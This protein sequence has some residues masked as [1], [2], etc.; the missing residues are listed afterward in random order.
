MKLALSSPCCNNCAIHSASLTSVLRPGTALMCCALTTSSSICPSRMLYTGFQSTALASLASKHLRSPLADR[1]PP[2]P[3]PPR[4][5]APPQAGH[6]HLLVHVQPTA[7]LV[8]NLHDRLLSRFHPAASGG[9][10]ESKSLLCA[11]LPAE[12][13]KTWCLRTPRS[14]SF[15]G[16]QHQA[17]IDLCSL[18]RVE[19]RLTFSSN[20][21]PQRRMKNSFENG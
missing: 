21:A 15:A 8:E 13:N 7:A 2:L 14:N 20:V 12:S 9:I 19:P 18:A 10:L 11:L 4:F 16:S 6:D 17:I 1:P 5:I 3:P